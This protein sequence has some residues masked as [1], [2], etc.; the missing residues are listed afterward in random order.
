MG[1]LLMNRLLM[2][3]FVLLLLCLGS[4]HAAT[5][6]DLKTFEDNSFV[7]LPKSDNVI[8]FEFYTKSGCTFHLKVQEGAM[9]TLTIGEEGSFR[10]IVTQ[11]ARSG[12]FL[13]RPI[14]VRERNYQGKQVLGFFIERALEWG[15]ISPAL[16]AMGVVNTSMIVASKM[17]TDVGS[18]TVPKAKTNPICPEQPCDGRSCCFFTTC[19]GR[20]ARYCT[21]GPAGCGGDGCGECCI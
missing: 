20:A 17:P 14:S 4:T 19:D 18:S 5:R 12:R 21:T 11:D 7:E 9:A 8:S 15:E 1:R 3:C 13:L 6:D 10:F 2:R 16:N